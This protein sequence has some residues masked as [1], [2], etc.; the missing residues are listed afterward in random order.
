MPRRLTKNRKPLAVIACFCTLL[1]TLICIGVQHELAEDRKET[2]AGAMQR[3]ANLAVALEQYAIRTIQSADMLLQMVKN[4]YETGREDNDLKMLV[5]NRMKDDVIACVFVADASGN[6]IAIDFKRDLHTLINVADQQHVRYHKAHPDGGLYMGTPINS[7]VLGKAVIPLSRRINNPDGSFFGTVT[8][9]IEPATFMRFYADA[10]LKEHDI[11]SL[12]SSN[13]YTF[14]RRTGMIDSYGEDVHKA[15]VYRYVAQV[16]AGNYFAKDALRGI[17]TFFSYRKL[18]HYP[19]IATVGTAEADVLAAYRKRAFLHWFVVA[20]LCLLIFLFSVVM[21]LLLLWRQ[22]HFR[23]V[24]ES[25]VKYRSVFENSLDAI[26]L[27]RPEIGIVAANKAACAFIGLPEAELLQ[28]TAAELVDSSDPG[29]EQ[30]VAE[31]NQ[32]GQ[33][34]GALQFVRS[35]GNVLIGEVAAAKYEDKAGE[36]YCIIIRDSTERVQLQQKLDAEQ[37]RYQRKVTRRVIQAQERERE[38]IGRELHDNVN[39][40]LTTVK[41]YLEM[42]LTYPKKSTDLLPKSISYVMNC[43]E[44]IRN[45]SRALSAPT[46]GTKSLI[47]SI[48]A[49]VEMMQPATKMRIHFTHNTYE[50][51]LTMDQ[52]LAIYRIV[53]EQ[54]NNIA[55]HAKATT[56]TIRLEQTQHTIT[57]LIKDNGQGFDSSAQR[58]GLGL[59]NMISRAK[60]FDGKLHIESAIGQGCLIE[61]SM[62][63]QQEAEAP[64]AVQHEA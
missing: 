40:I 10:D 42:T 30:L 1:I 52:K 43:I 26:V 22:R 38:V 51:C 58:N 9:Q 18:Q 55:K 46:L 19:V 31:A 39:Q 63:V 4:E 20:I 35:D 3:N 24:R 54:L 59:N 8:V 5:S 28:R 41:L 2:I 53:Q 60:V 14:A 48:T 50:C 29:F 34:Q 13:G 27:M 7:R 15:G 12:L 23:L 11:I 32:N 6:V 45:I 64:N 17:P 33:A 44:E 47:D 57:L 49:L 25:E 37:K 62:P 56:V 36:I 61:M 21:S 16:S